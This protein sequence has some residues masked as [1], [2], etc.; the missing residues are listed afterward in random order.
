MYQEEELLLEIIAENYAIENNFDEIL[1]ENFID[2]IKKEYTELQKRDPNVAGM[3]KNL[4]YTTAGP[5]G[6]L[7]YGI[8]QKQLM[9]KGKIPKENFII[10]RKTLKGLGYPLLAGIITP[11]GSA[12]LS[13]LLGDEY[14]EPKPK[15][16]AKGAKKK[17]FSLKIKKVEENCN[18]YYTEEELLEAVDIL[19]EDY[20]IDE[21][22]AIDMIAEAY[23][24]ELLDEAGETVEQ[25]EQVSHYYAGMN[26]KN[27]PKKPSVA[28]RIKGVYTDAQDAG[29]RYK[30]AKVDLQNAKKIGADEVDGEYRDVAASNYEQKQEALK[31]ARKDYAVASAKAAAPGVLAIGGT[32]G[33][34]IAHKAYKNHKAKKEAEARRRRSL[35]GRLSRR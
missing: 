12:A 17:E 1:T 32:A 27:N 30:K 31:K 25:K 24:M 23:E 2:D 4:I 13:A 6:G 5:V 9:K 10:L 20:G 16:K 29:E 19:V 21:D 34:V 22:E 8:R 11:V 26:H 14:E 33:A 3:V 35:R 28:S 18:M 15:V 7:V